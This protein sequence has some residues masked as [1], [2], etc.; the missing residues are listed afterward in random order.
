[1]RP[2]DKGLNSIFIRLKVDSSA[3]RGGRYEAAHAFSHPDVAMAIPRFRTKLE[4]LHA[5][6]VN[7]RKIWKA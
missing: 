3:W 7:S 6:Y 1:M 4:P 2:K 5:I